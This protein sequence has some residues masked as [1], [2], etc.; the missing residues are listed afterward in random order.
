M[1]ERNDLEKSQSVR[2]AKAV[3]IGNRCPEGLH[4]RERDGTGEAEVGVMW[5]HNPRNAGSL[6]LE[7][8][9]SR[10]LPG[11]PPAAQSCRTMFGF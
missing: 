5:G 4:W 1:A 7:E 8:A 9:R 2:I 10:I 3:K 11:P 6:E